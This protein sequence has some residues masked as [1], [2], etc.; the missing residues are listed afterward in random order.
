MFPPA[1][2][3]GEEVFRLLEGDRAARQ[4]EEDIASLSTTLGF[5]EAI[6]EVEGWSQEVR[7]KF[8][9][10]VESILK[11]MPNEIRAKG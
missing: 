2:A 4:K 9:A 8:D 7:D 6:F 3:T 5:R 1:D 11:M 10:M